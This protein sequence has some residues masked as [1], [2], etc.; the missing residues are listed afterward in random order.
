VYL[1]TLY[2]CYSFGLWKPN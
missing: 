1:T 2:A